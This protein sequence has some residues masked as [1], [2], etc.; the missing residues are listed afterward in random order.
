M[1]THSLRSSIAHPPRLRLRAAVPLG[2]AFSASG[3]LALRTVDSLQRDSLL[4]AG[5]RARSRGN[6]HGGRRGSWEVSW[7]AGPRGPG[8]I[9]QAHPGGS[10][11][12]ASLGL[13]LGAVSSGHS[14]SLQS[15]ALAV[16]GAK[17]QVQ[18]RG[19]GSAPISASPWVP[20]A[21][22]RAVPMGQNSLTSRCSPGADGLTC[23]LL[24]PENFRFY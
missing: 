24:L 15:R 3:M 22:R 19:L 23:L 7:E 10:S 5:G 2:A 6:G 12:P 17:D 4:H 18:G 16:E 11:Q 14:L 9:P 13:A 21:S 20:A 8:M 1:Q